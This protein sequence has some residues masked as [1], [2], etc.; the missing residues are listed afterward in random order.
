MVPLR[1]KHG[2]IKSGSFIMV[3]LR[4]KH[5]EIKSGPFMMVPFHKKRNEIKS[6]SFEMVPSIKT[7]L[8]GTKLLL[9]TSRKHCPQLHNAE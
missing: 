1:K 9:P 2:E 5:S 8:R 7:L 3:P 4:K 6:G